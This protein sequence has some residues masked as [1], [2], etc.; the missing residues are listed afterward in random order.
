M[1]VGS[2]SPDNKK[3]ELYNFGIGKWKT[4]D[5]YPFGTNRYMLFDMLYLPI[6]S[7][8]LVIGGS[9]SSGYLSQIAAFKNGVWS[10]VGK[11]NS[12]REVSFRQL[13]KLLTITD[14]TLSRTAPSGSTTH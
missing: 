4:V 9:D 8:Y 1:A 7:T 11:L 13:S 12:P 6:T 10:D 2:Y 3:A 14:P 5:D